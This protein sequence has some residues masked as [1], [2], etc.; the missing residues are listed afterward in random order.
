MA[1]TRPK[2]FGHRYFPTRVDGQITQITLPTLNLSEMAE[3]GI[4]L[5][6]NYQMDLQDLSRLLK[7]SLRLR[8]LTTYVYRNP[9]TTPGPA[10][11]DYASSTPTI[12]NLIANYIARRFLRTCTVGNCRALSSERTR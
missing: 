4:D 1:C 8:A 3:R 10:T 6:T 11:I 12:V 9:S 2:S 7:G 5:E